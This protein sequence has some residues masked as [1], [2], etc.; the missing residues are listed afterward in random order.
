[1]AGGTADGRAVSASCAAAVHAE[2][3]KRAE[4]DGVGRVRSFEP[5]P[6]HPHRHIK[7]GS[8]SETRLAGAQ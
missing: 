5:Y 8:A 3:E 1:M 4:D 7:S 6:G 2:Q